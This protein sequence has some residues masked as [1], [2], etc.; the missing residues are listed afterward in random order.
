MKTVLDFPGKTFATTVFR[1]QPKIACLH[2]EVGPDRR[3]ACG[4]FKL[5][6]RFYESPGTSPRIRI[7]NPAAPAAAPEKPD[8][9]T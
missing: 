1:R 6:V 9:L 7:L 3:R 5:N 4:R 8:G 2:P